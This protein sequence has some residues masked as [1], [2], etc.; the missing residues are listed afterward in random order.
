MADSPLKDHLYDYLKQ[1][2][3]ALLWKLDGLS[4]YDARR[5]LTASGTSVLGVIKHVATV[6]L[7]YL[8]DCFGRPSDIA[9]PWMSEDSEPMTDMYAAA[10]ESREFIIDLY[11]RGSALADATI[12]AL[13]LDAAGHVPWWHPDK[14]DV[15]LGQILIHLIAE[16]H[17]HA[18]QV[19]IVREMID[20]SAGW[21]QEMP[22][23]DGPEEGWPA[24]CER[25]E[26][27]AASFM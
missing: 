23:M 19:D 7:G 26:G 15:T 2:R 20:N 21:K 25:L 11:R 24:Y 9:L 17:R 12:E 10:D 27:I 22:L 5:P 4:E 18:G 3:A 6:E 14:A 16:T 1:G 13:P 8:T